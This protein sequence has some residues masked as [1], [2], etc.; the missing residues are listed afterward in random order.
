[1]Q[2]LLRPNQIADLK[3]EEQQLLGK[4]KQ[5][6]SDKGAISGQ[7]KRLNKQIETQSPKP[8]EGK[9]KDNAI[10]AQKELLETLREG[11]PSHEEMRKAPPGA[12]DKHMRW[13]KRNKEN[14]IRWK[15][16]ELRLNHDSDDV[17]IANL[18]KYRPTASSLNMGNAF[19]PGTQYF[20][21]PGPVP[22][23]NVASDADKKLIAEM[24]EKLVEQAVANQDA[25]LAK[26]LGINL[27]DYEVSD[28]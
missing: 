15:N 27:S 1:M 3:Q 5:H 28:K 19:I 6:D 21:P 12:V 20:M 13:E 11:M 16:N 23:T 2:N 4:F 26:W 25:K 7:L 24:N 22:V 8:F 10:Q 17:E 14:I 18:E 9:E